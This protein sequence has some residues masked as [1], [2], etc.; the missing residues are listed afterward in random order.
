MALRAFCFHQISIPEMRTKTGC[1]PHAVAAGSPRD[2]RR[3]A[4]AYTG[5]RDLSTNVEAWDS[6]TNSRTTISCGFVAANLPSARP[7]ASSPCR[8]LSS[9]CQSSS[10]NVEL[11]RWTV[12]SVG[13]LSIL[14][15]PE[16]TFADWGLDPW[17][18]NLASCPPRRE[19][20]CGSRPMGY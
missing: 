16:D 20:P 10:S 1:F 9:I 14:D 18:V 5:N 6:R 11:T 15:L 4:C 12:D 13:N 2:T 19:G 8:Q 17:H 3:T 7:Q